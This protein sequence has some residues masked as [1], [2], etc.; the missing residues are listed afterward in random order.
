[1]C[2]SY[3]LPTYTYNLSIIINPTPG[4]QRISPLFIYHCIL[5]PHIFFLSSHCP[6]WRSSVCMP[7]FSAESFT[8]IV[9]TELTLLVSNES[10]LYA[11]CFFFLVFVNC[12]LLLSFLCSV[13][14]SKQCIFKSC[15]H[16]L[17]LSLSYLCLSRKIKSSPHVCEHSQLLWMANNILLQTFYF[18]NGSKNCFRAKML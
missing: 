2:C 6:C 3:T 12:F 1:M 14:K 17:L 8:G 11:C 13:R 5:E 7:Y 16:L 10:H 15:W 18:E 9:K 4:S